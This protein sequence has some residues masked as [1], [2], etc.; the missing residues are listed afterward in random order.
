MINVSRI[1]R[2]EYI[3]FFEKVSIAVDRIKS[4]DFTVA[5]E[6]RVVTHDPNE[7]IVFTSE[8]CEAVRA[9]LHANAIADEQA[10]SDTGEEVSR[11]GVTIPAWRRDPGGY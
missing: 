1:G 7:V 5:K 11:S 3:N 10:V 2:R 8:R 6:V 9:Y 4:F